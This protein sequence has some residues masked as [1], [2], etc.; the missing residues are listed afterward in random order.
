MAQNEREEADAAIAN[1]AAFQGLYE[2]SAIGIALFSIG[3]RFLRANPAL[4]RLLGYSEEELLQKTHLDTVHL[5]DREATA[6]ARAQ[7]ISGKSKPRLTERRYVHKD[8]SPIWAHASGAVVRDGAGAPLCT[9]LLVV[10]V[11]ALKKGLRAAKR[12]FRR[13]IEMGSDWYWVQD[14]EFRFVEVPGV[15]L[16][17]LDADSDIVIGKSRWE[18]PG[19][20]ALPEK[21]WEQHRARLARHES[22]S[23]F[24]F[25]RYNKAGELRY[26]SVSGEPLFDEHGN[27]RGYHG[28]GKDI[29]ERARDQKALEEG[30]RRYRTLFDSNPYPM[31]VAD[32]KS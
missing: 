23:D 18:L 1:G 31:W 10:D 32:A 28:V 7:A 8:G 24:V 9:V 3:G 14:P 11:S 16:D 4:C 30:A 27:F 29:S 15:A 26:L 13:L 25:L 12:R 20:V 5:D 21:V 17:E 2:N 22:F 6:V 19:L